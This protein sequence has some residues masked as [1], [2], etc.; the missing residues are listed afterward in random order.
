M[1]FISNYPFNQRFIKTFLAYG[2][3][4]RYRGAGPTKLAQYGAVGAIVRSM[5][6]STDNYPHTG[7]TYYTIHFQNIP[8]VAIGLQDADWLSNALTIGNVSVQ[9]K[10]NGLFS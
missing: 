7:S 10:T 8:A 5:S 1:F 4:V 2:D 3:A 9:M 6:E